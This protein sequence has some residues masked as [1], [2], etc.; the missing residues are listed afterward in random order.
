MRLLM[1]N[2]DHPLADKEI[3]CRQADRG[4]IYRP[5]VAALE[6][7]AERCAWQRMGEA[8]VDCLKEALDCALVPRLP[9]WREMHRDPECEARLL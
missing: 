8:V 9:P 2:I 5:I 4:F 3:E 1:V 7:I 6:D